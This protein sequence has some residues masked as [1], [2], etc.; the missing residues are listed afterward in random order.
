MA[1]RVEI[2]W[3]SMQ[4]ILKTFPVKEGEERAWQESHYT[5]VCGN[6]RAFGD[7][8]CGEAIRSKTR[9]TSIGCILLDSKHFVDR[10]YA[11]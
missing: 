11:T 6:C 1:A 10:G 2:I 4:P 7:G 8:K 3:D 9:H 5:R